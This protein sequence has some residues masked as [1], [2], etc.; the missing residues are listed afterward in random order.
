M[1][2]E[3]MVVDVRVVIASYRPRTMPE[4]AA[5]FARATVTRVEPASAARAKAL[6]WA[7]ARLATFGIS[8]GL[9]A[10]PAVLLHPSVMERFVL[11][12]CA[13]LSGAARRTLRTNLR[14]VAARVMARV[15]PVALSRERAKQ[16]YSDAQIA[17]YLAL[18]DAQ[19]TLA[20]R[21]RAQG[22]I[23]LGAGAGLM[24]ADLRRARGIDVVSAHGGLVVDVAGRRPR[25]VPVLERF[26]QRLVASAAFAGQGWV[27][28]GVDPMRHNVTTPL[29]SSLAGGVELGRLDTG[30]LRVSWLAA[31]ADRMGIKAFMDAAG[32]TCSQ[33]L[34]DVLAR[35]AIPSEA[36]A[37]AILGGCR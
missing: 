37:V 36:D 3:L 29:I 17:A 13:D 20:R 10:E 22:L 6:L 19:P 35:L 23:C 21:M 28:G 31:V 26:H 5:V 18:A 32:I 30:R 9:E 24:G 34:G 2:S 16:P 33:R 27:I 12:G 4:G 8:V 1:A 7:C 14:H 25:V 11:V 15:G